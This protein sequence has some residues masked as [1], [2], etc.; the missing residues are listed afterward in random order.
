MEI[1]IIGCAFQMLMDS[2]YPKVM[3]QDIPGHKTDENMRHIFVGKE[4]YRLG[5][6]EVRDGRE[7]Q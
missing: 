1:T 7:W 6:G 2:T 4:R 5:W 3:T